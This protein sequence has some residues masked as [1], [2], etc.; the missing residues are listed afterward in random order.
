MIRREREGLRWYVFASIPERSVIHGAFTRLG[1]VSEAPFAGLNVGK[2][3][4]DREA[5]V[6]ANHHALAHALGVE[7]DRLVDA[8]QVHG[9]RVAAVTAEHAGQT[10]PETDALITNVPGIWLLLRFADCVPVF[11]YDPI[12]Q[13]VGLAHAGWKGTLAEIARKTVG[14]MASTYGSDPA[15]LIVGLGPAIGSCC[16]EVQEDVLLPLRGHYGAVAENWVRRQADGAEHLDLWL[17][18]RWQLE[19]AGVVHIEES[20]LCT[21]CRQDEFYSYRGENGITGRFAALIGLCDFEA[22]R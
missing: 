10:L 8:Q 11:L 16:F 3:V 4:G 12:R 18:N 22:G 1:G 7:V 20:G 6:R 5:A 2:H 15:E 13:A 14:A 9:D 21:C 17:A 19:N